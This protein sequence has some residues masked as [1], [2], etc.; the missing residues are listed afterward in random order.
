MTVVSACDCLA[1]SSLCAAFSKASSVCKVISVVS[2]LSSGG[3]MPACLAFEWYTTKNRKTISTQYH[4]DLKLM[5]CVIGDY[6]HTRAH[7]H[8]ESGMI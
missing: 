1:I 3:G 6:T 8:T 7:T 2:A 4:D 5:V